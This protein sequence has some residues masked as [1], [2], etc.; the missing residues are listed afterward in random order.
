MG[1]QHNQGTENECDNHS[2]PLLGKDQGGVQEYGRFR[3]FLSCTHMTALRLLGLDF[4]GHVL[5][6][7]SVHLSQSSQSPSCGSAEPVAGTSLKVPVSLLLSRDLL[8]DI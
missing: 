3:L 2:S 4:G 5:F 7:S 1:T 8:H 6:H